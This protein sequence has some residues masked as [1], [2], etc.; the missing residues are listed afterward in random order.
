VKLSRAEHAEAEDAEEAEEAG[1]AEGAVVQAGAA[2]AP[3]AALR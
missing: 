1:E 3:A 2:E